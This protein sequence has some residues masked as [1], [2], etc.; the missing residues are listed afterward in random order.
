VVV[1]R[2]ILPFDAKKLEV[3]AVVAKKLVAVALLSTV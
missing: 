3:E 1:A 2:D